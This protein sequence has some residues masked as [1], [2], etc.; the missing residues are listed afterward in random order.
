MERKYR[1]FICYRHLPLDTA[2]AQKLHKMIE[3]YRIPKDL[4]KNG[5]KQLGLVFRDRDEL[6]LSSDLSRDIYTALDNSDFLIVI[7]TPDTP[8][9]LWVRQEIEHFINVHGRER[10]ITVLAAG[11]PDESIPDCITTVHGTDGVT[12]IEPLCAYL[13]DENPRKVLWNLR[14]EFLRLAAALIGCP[15]DALKQRHKR[16]RMMQAMWSKA[17]SFMTEDT[18]GSVKRCSAAPTMQ[19]GCTAEAAGSPC[20]SRSA[21][22]SS[23][24]PTAKIPTAPRRNR[25]AKRNSA[26][27]LQTES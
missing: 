20:A 13:V 10:I 6:P 24:C 9:S 25:K 21:P 19:P 27:I 15:Y 12:H 5:Q 4:Q 18:G 26:R 16:Y 11:T 1:A 7:C 2:V 3:C 23:F 17:P 8:K 22:L 14:S